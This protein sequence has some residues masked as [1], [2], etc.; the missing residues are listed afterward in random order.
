MKIPNKLCCGVAINVVALSLSLSL[1]VF[2]ATDFIRWTRRGPTR[3][4][5]SINDVA[6]V[7]A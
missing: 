2:S 5:R 4:G 7:H 1:S 6:C 3:G